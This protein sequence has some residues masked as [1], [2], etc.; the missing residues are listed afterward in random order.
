[1]LTR[2]VSALNH[3]TAH[4]GKRCVLFLETMK[5]PNI[6]IVLFVVSFGCTKNHC[7]DDSPGFVQVTNT[8]FF[9]ENSMIFRFYGDDSVFVHHIKDSIELYNLKDFEPKF[10]TG[11]IKGKSIVFEYYYEN[12]GCEK[13][14]DDEYESQLCFEIPSNKSNFV[15]TFDDLNKHCVFNESYFGCPECC[16][17]KMKFV[18]GKIKGKKDIDNN[19]NI[20]AK[21]FYCCIDSMNN[22]GDPIKIMFTGK[23][24]NHNY[25]QCV[26][27]LIKR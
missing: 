6:Y 18:R 2:Q 19:W 20:K 24:I 1:M 16:F 5:I 25:N 14:T 17:Q 7:P 10:L 23:F 22:Y 4:T 21:I 26:N 8:Y 12:L 27:Y 9:H 3:A 15:L 13:K 11:I